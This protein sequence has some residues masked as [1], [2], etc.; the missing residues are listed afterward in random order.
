[1]A[2]A[3]DADQPQFVAPPVAGIPYRF[4]ALAIVCL[5][6]FLG[7]LDTSIINIALPTLAAEFDVSSGDVI[8]VSLI[9]ILVSTG[10]GLS[11]GRLGDLYG[12]KQLYIVGFALFTVAAGFAAMAG[13]L[14]ELLG[15]RAV[16]AVGASMVLANGAAII[17]ATFPV[18]QRG[19]GLGI[20][21][22]TVGAGVATGPVLGGVLMEVL[23]W[24][25]I[26][27]VRIPFGL[28]GSLL[29]A[30]FLVDTPPDQRPRGLDL[31]GSLTL[32]LMLGGAVLAVNRG[33]AWGWDSAKVVGLF[34][35]SAVLA[36]VFVL[37]ER[38]STGPVVDLGLFRKR[39]FSGGIVSAI[40]QFFGLSAVIILMPFY[41]VEA[42]GFSTLEAG[43]I[44]AAFPIA[45]LVVSPISGLLA[46]RVSAPILTTAGLLVVTGGLIFCA[47]LTVETSV[48]GIVARLFMVGCGTAIFSS[49]NTSAIMS[50]VPPDR[51]GTASAAQTTARTIGNAIGI[52][53]A[54]AILTSHV[55]SVVARDSSAGLGDPELAADAIVSGVRLALVVAAAMAAFAIPP[56]LLRGKSAAIPVARDAELAAASAPPD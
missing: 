52:A 19:M 22:A 13:S 56:A 27:W 10:L 51:L 6:I 7:T 28:V 21:V 23:D 15:A 25:A 39:A 45:M 4:V 31:A 54:G 12:R 9:F 55:A 48:A 33:D 36:V 24:R 17:T 38:R 35:L 29:V 47:T 42:R 53:V 16:Q 41:L 26:F 44:M 18:S 34:S 50:A 20:M 8:W 1:L 14:P 3:T 40:F 49:P 46:D 32:F 43:G 11:M 30:R 5:G 2:E 37:I